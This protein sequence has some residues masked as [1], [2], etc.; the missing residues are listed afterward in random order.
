MPRKSSFKKICFL[1]GTLLA[2]TLPLTACSDK[3]PDNPDDSD[4]IVY[5]TV[6]FNSNGG[7]PVPSVQVPAGSAVS[8]PP[9]PTQENRIFKGWMY[10]NVSWMFTKKVTGN[11][12]LTAAWEDASERF[13]Y[14]IIDGYAT[15]TGVKNGSSSKTLTIPQTIAGFTVNAIGEAAFANTLQ[16]Q[17]SS[18][19]L[20]S[21]VTSI[22]DDAFSNCV[23]ITFAFSGAKLTEIG[24]NAFENCNALTDIAFGEGLT[25]ISSNAFFKCESLTSLVFPAS[26]TAVEESAF[27]GCIN[28]SSLLMHAGVREIGHSA[29]RDCDRLNSLLFGGS[30]EEFQ[31]VLSHTNSHMNDAFFDFEDSVCLYSE[32]RPEVAGSFWYYDASH[33]P[34]L[35]PT[36]ASA[37]STLGGQT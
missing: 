35:W 25:E 20:P 32:T 33:T 2:L 24:E 21:T 26:L 8:E 7:T 17:F 28:L 29:F 15:V 4:S 22:G 30:A 9:A 10:D 31:T 13:E 1:L 12:T 16:E 23:D 6:T 5:Y 18:I 37:E 14:E 11:M 19:I 3:N 27:E 36:V 34:K